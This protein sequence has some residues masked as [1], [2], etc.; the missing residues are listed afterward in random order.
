MSRLS[1]VTVG[2]WQAKRDYRLG[3]NDWCVTYQGC[4]VGTFTMDELSVGD[5]LLTLER[6]RKAEEPQQHRDC[7]C[8][9]C[10]SARSH[11]AT[12]SRAHLANLL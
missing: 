5:T 9:T 6:E 11:F 1:I 12:T 3:E 2:K 8:S 10:Q 7:R 4:Y